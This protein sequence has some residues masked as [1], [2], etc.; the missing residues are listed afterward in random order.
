MWFVCCCC[1]CPGI[2]RVKN[3]LRLTAMNG[4]NLQPDQLREPPRLPLSL[5]C[6]G[7]LKLNLLCVGVCMCVCVPVCVLVMLAARIH[8]CGA[9]ENPSD[10]V[11]CP[12]CHKY[13]LSA[14]LVETAD[15][16]A[17]ARYDIIAKVSCRRSELVCRGMAALG[18][19]CAVLRACGRVM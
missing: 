19:G 10:P 17:S 13:V 9:C 11:S 8:R 18:R 3:V 12:T 2:S 16:F 14:G 7:V 5:S 6:R 15:L 4:D 1:H